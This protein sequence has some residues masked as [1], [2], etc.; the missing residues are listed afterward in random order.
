M[1]FYCLS[2]QCTKL[3]LGGKSTLRTIQSDS[4]VNTV[5]TAVPY[6]VADI[7]KDTEDLDQFCV[8]IVSVSLDYI[9][10]VLKACKIFL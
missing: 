2:Y 10:I 8:N 5:S 3:Y 9:K 1:Q 4:F 6:S 7:I